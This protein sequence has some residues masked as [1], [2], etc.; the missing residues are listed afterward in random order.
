VIRA[1]ALLFEGR[2]AFAAAPEG[3]ALH[4]AIELRGRTL[5]ELE[6]LAIRAALVRN[7]GKRYAVAEELGIARS[8]LLRKL[9]LLGLRE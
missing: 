8:T 7:G 9:D 1:S 4:G 5:G 6:E 2:P 3:E